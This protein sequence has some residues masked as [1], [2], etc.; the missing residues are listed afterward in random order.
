MRRFP[1]CSSS[2]GPLRARAA[3]IVMALAGS[4]FAGF[5]TAAAQTDPSSV[6]DLP[7]DSSPAP[8]SGPSMTVQL[9]F[10]GQ[11]KIGDWLPVTVQVSNSGASVTG[12]L[13]IVVD[14]EAG[15]TQRNRTLN[16]RPPTVYTVPAS[17]PSNSR[18]QYQID[19]F[20]PLPAKS[21][22][23]KLVTDQGVLVT[24][25]GNLQALSGSDVLCGTL[26]GNQDFF[27]L[28]KNIDLPGRQG[29]KP[30]IVALKPSDL[31]PR[32]HALSSLDCLIVNNVSMMGLTA[33]QKAALV[34]W[35]D[36]GGLLILGGGSGWQ[37]TLQPLPKE[38][39]PVDVTGVKSI[40]SMQ[41]LVD[42]AQQPLKGD[43]PW[44]VSAGKVVNGTV[45]AQDADVP[46]LV[47]ARRGKGAVVYL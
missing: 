6:A 46:L 19:V 44:L 42:F 27:Q 15:N 43:G 22:D 24:A 36:D 3:L 26:S 9:G 12:E 45:V 47:G 16:A 37:K 21:L 31:P 41:S 39:L 2:G 17:L 13:Q 11:A 7:P 14:D 40:P 25:T 35:V 18:K 32:Q 23:V 34:G 20:L 33:D 8:S 28:L 1:A 4:L 30:S 29:K 10:A 5:G 38:L